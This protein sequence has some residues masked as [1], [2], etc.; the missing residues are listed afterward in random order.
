MTPSRAGEGAKRLDFFHATQQRLQTF[1]PA[2]L[3]LFQLAVFA[4]QLFT[5]MLRALNFLHQGVVLFFQLFDLQ[6]KQSDGINR[7]LKLRF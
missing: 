3:L 7:M 1:L 2:L 4:L 6:L 5:T